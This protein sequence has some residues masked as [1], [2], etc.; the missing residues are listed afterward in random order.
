VNRRAIA[1]VSQGGA[2]VPRI[3]VGGIGTGGHYF[4]AIVVAQALQQRSFNTIFLARRGSME[5]KAA[6]TC[7]L[8][9]FT[10][11]AKPFYGKSLLR[12]L[13][14]IFSLLFSVYRL[15]ALTS[16]GIALAFGGFGAVPL[17]LS[18]WMNRSD[19]YIFEPNRVP[20]RATMRFASRAKRVFLGLGSVSGLQRRAVVTGIPVRKEF[21]TGAAGFLRRS[22]S[23]TRSILFY[24][25]SQGARRL[26]DLALELQGMLSNQW[27]FTIICGTHDHERLMRLKTDHTR[28]LPFTNKPWEEIVNA[29]IIVSRSGALAGYELLC[30]DKKVI[31]IP[32]PHAIDDH[33]YYNAEYFARIGDAIFIREED[34]SA[35]IL[36]T[37][38]RELL[39]RKRVSKTRIVKDAEAKIVEYIL[40]DLANEKS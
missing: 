7:G 1:E 29:D 3:V 2:R 18:C 4:P 31:F 25:G 30:L 26:N 35:E 24:G 13:M 14:F 11:N 16:H 38:I 6:R 10:V 9:V 20:G 32:F 34:L 40:G 22:K 37:R 27:R 39:N 5:E 12:K 36:A 28:V 23:G 8:R 33:Q 15:H 17:I 21:K 19:Y